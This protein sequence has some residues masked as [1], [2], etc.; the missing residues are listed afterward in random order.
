M[1]EKLNGYEQRCSDISSFNVSVLDEIRTKSANRLIIGNFNINSLS[2]KFDLLK[3]LIQ[4]KTDILIITETKLDSI[5]SLEQ[6][7]INGYSKPYRLD[8]NR[9]GEG[10][11]YIGEDMPR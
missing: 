8:R 10:V 1:D 4:E 11:I 3:V 2:T 9:S 6:F 7:V 5:C